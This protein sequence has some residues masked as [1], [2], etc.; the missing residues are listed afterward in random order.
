MFTKLSYIPS[1]PVLSGLAGSADR[2]TLSRHLAI[3]TGASCAQT[4]ETK[5]K[6]R[7]CILPRRGGQGSESLPGF[8][9]QVTTPRKS[10]LLSFQKGWWPTLCWGG[11]STM[12]LALSWE[13]CVTGSVTIRVSHDVRAPDT[14]PVASP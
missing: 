11:M 7:V 13:E 3:C 4:P 5:G 8:L 2:A 9:P 14:W 10:I 12:P 6:W 1:R